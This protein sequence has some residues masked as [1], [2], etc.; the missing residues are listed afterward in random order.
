MTIKRTIFNEISDAL[1]SITGMR[2]PFRFYRAFASR[3]D[4]IKKIN[5]RGV[6]MVFDANEELHLLRAN[7]L[8]TKEPETLDWIDAFQ[9]RS[10]LYDIGANVGV[11][12]LYS[13]LKK[14]CKVV[15]I[16]PESQNYAC[17]NKNIHHNHLD[18]DIAALNIGLY[19]RTAVNVLNLNTMQSGAANHS[20]GNAV[21]WAG[22]KYE[23]VFRQ[24]VLSFTLDSLIEYFV[25]D[26]PNYI[27]IDVDGNESKILEGA[28]ETL[29]NP[30]LKSVLIEMRASDAEMPKLMASYGFTDMKIYRANLQKGEDDLTNTIFSKA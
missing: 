20:V 26:I 3:I 5:V 1:I 19:D 28:K 29:S 17:L 21:T 6:D 23:P 10:V 27:K 24:A 12:S 22:D 9:D 14:K 30:E 15:A 4:V 13:A 16:E 11:F 18:N 7:I 8:N 25:L 2:R